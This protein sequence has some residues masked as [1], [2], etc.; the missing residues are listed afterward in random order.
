MKNL[1]VFF[2]LLGLILSQFALSSTQPEEPEKK[3]MRFRHN[4][5]DSFSNPTEQ[6]A[7]ALTMQIEN[8]ISQDPKNKRK[9]LIGMC[10]AHL[11][12]NVKDQRTKI[13][14][15]HIF[16]T[17]IN[18][19]DSI[20]NLICGHL[21]TVAMVS[22]YEKCL[23]ALNNYDPCK[24]KARHNQVKIWAAKF[25]CQIPNVPGTILFEHLHE[26]LQTLIEEKKLTLDYHKYFQVLEKYDPKN[27]PLEKHREMKEM[28][29]NLSLYYLPKIP[30]TKMFK[31]LCKHLET[32]IEEKNLMMPPK[33]RGRLR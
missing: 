17:N 11:K 23:E 9:I 32:L 15:L 12:K 25:M 29:T 33:K 24:A 20:F 2:L 31:S 5:S 28:A 30:R 7:F 4:G 13:K 16:S 10:C 14:L 8:Q 26:K 18:K 27:A 19:E 22:K 6:E 21:I 1:N 3:R